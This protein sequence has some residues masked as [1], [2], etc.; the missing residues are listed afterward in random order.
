MPVPYA[1]LEKNLSSLT[2]NERK[3]FFSGLQFVGSHLR[4]AARTDNYEVALTWETKDLLRNLAAAFHSMAF[5]GKLNDANQYHTVWD[6]I[7]KVRDPFEFLLGDG[8]N[9]KSVYE[10]A[11][12]DIAR[13]DMCS[14]EEAREKFD[15]HLNAVSG[16]L[17]LGIDVEAL[18][19]GKAAYEEKKQREAEERARREEEE[20]KQREAEERARKEQEERERQEQELA[21]QKQEARDAAA[22]AQRELAESLGAH[23]TSQDL[24]ADWAALRSGPAG[25]AAEK[26]HGAFS[27]YADSLA[28]ELKGVEEELKNPPQAD[29]A[30]PPPAESPEERKAALEKKLA[31]ARKWQKAFGSFLK[32]AEQRDKLNS[33]DK[34]EREQAKEAEDRFLEDTAPLTGFS[35]WLNSA[36]GKELFHETALAAKKKGKSLDELSDAALMMDRMAKYG[37]QDAAMIRGINSPYLGIAEELNGT[38]DPKTKSKDKGFLKSF[39][40]SLKANREELR[41]GSDKEKQLAEKLRLLIENAE[42]LEESCV[43]FDPKRPGKNLKEIAE[44]TEKFDKQLFEVMADKEGHSLCEEEARRWRALKYRAKSPNYAQKTWKNYLEF[45]TDLFWEHGKESEYIAKAL[46]A[47]QHINSN[48]PKDRSFSKKKARKEA[49]TLS[50]DPAFRYLMKT[51]GPEIQQLMKEGKYSEVSKMVALPFITN[52]R[53]KLKRAY[54]DLE[55]LQKFFMSRVVS[56]DSPREFRELNQHIEKMTKEF[57]KRQ[58]DGPTNEEMGI[59]LGE[60]FRKTEKFLKGRKAEKKLGSDEELMTRFSLDAMDVMSKV[61]GAGKAKVQAVFDRTNEVR[62]NFGRHQ[63]PAKFGQFQLE[64]RL[65]EQMNAWLGE[66]KERKDNVK[67]KLALDNGEIKAGDDYKVEDLPEVNEQMDFIKDAVEMDPQNPTQPKP[68]KLLDVA[69]MKESIRTKLKA[70]HDLPMDASYR[71]TRDAFGLAVTPVFKQRQKDG[72][73]K[74]VCFEDSLNYRVGNF[75][76]VAP[77]NQIR[78]KDKRDLLRETGENPC[79]QI[80]DLVI[81]ATKAAFKYSENEIKGSSQEALETANSIDKS[82]GLQP[83]FAA[84]QVE[85][86]VNQL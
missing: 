18:H 5:A 66:V 35:A 21:R 49:E 25:A 81:D 61:T 28:E 10:A 53:E 26:L 24:L 80:K 68:R 39:I 62:T 74:A 8:G 33:Q 29:D 78:E 42:A 70:N 45:H 58:P 86:P 50:K 56:G 22:K 73:Y 41:D 85:A 82:Y 51:K 6:L 4:E 16:P 11:V 9:G 23:F 55:K 19:M 15:R 47:Y 71:L 13:E 84:P 79:H 44:K 36:E 46:V 37:P 63:T 27:D 7:N 83:S 17:G 38:Y 12:A 2:E 72:S 30:L 43:G 3:A 48:D 14:V 32:G 57:H 34:K 60:A 64:K 40:A 76:L 20:R 59:Q 69:E 67:E 75:Q 54:A 31:E 1:Q 77:A 52:D 65:Q